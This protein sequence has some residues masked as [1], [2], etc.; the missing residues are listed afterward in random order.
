M[1]DLLDEAEELRKK[2][3]TYNINLGVNIDEAG[4]VGK[5]GGEMNSTAAASA[6]GNQTPPQ[7]DQGGISRQ[8]RMGAR[9]HGMVMGDQGV[10]RR[11]RDEAQ[12]AQ[13]RVPDQAGKIKQLPSDDMQKDI[14][15]GV[16]GKQVDTEEPTNWN[17]DDKGTFTEDIAQRMQKVAE[18]NVIVERQD[19]KMD[20]RV[21]DM[22]RDLESDQEQVIERLKVIKKELKGLFLPTD[23][24]DEAIKNLT[25]NLERL[26]ERPSG[27]IFRLQ[28]ETLDK[29]RGSLNVFTEYGAGYQPSLT[30]DQAVRGRV[31]DEQA[32]QPIPGYEEAVKNYYEAL[33]KP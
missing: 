22:L 5:Q 17:T 23:Q 33:A 30:R 4:D 6:T 1:G 27:D 21:A 10:N 11:G 32:R 12:D 15:T 28:A 20:P 3:D 14:S 9:A 24:V 2:Y 13:E 18:K 7:H 31:L 19:G 25:A 29:L 26:K 16:G 8:G